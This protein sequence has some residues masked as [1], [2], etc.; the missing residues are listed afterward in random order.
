MIGFSFMLFCISESLL[1]HLLGAI[2]ITQFVSLIC[3]IMSMRANDGCS[4]PLMRS[5][6]NYHYIRARGLGGDGPE[7]I[8]SS[9]SAEFVVTLRNNRVSKKN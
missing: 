9:V 8:I 5:P 3:A 7:D 6:A 4:S 2:H 1:L